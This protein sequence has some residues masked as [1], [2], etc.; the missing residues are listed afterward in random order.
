MGQANVSIETK[1]AAFPHG[2]PLIVQAQFKHSRLQSL[3]RRGFAPT[4]QILNL[5][6]SKAQP[7]NLGAQVAGDFKVN[8]AWR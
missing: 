4:H 3:D 7:A 2:T 5:I 6:P 8:Y 1:I